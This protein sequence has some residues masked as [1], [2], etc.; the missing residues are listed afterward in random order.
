MSEHQHTCPE[1]APASESRAFRNSINLEE[2]WTKITDLAGRR[3][4]QNRIAQRKHRNKLKRRLE[5]LERRVSQ[6]DST[7]AA[8]KQ[9]PAESGKYQSQSS[10]QTHIMPAST[11]TLHRGLS[12]CPKHADKE[13]H[14]SQTYN[15]GYGR[16][17]ADS[18]L[19]YLTYPLLQEMLLAPLQ[20]TQ[21]CPIT[22]EIYP[23]QP[24][25]AVPVTLFPVNHLNGA[26]NDVSKLH[27]G[28]DDRCAYIN[29]NYVSAPGFCS[30]KSCNLS[31]SL[32]QPL[33]R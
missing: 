23:T 10:V 11:E 5:D 21:P 13:L 6:K 29:Y 31:P 14:F 1:T 2:D 25:A 28:G 7:A 12:I 33:E 26:T 3:R 20:N 30:P 18:Q 24:T 32:F 22:T 9:T 19:D 16:S 27:S 4:I 17:N 8:Q 15:D